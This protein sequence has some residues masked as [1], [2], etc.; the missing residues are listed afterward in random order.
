[1]QWLHRL[2]LFLRSLRARLTIW[3]SAVV[4]VAVM[5]A[6][7]AV[8]EGLRFS[9]LAETDVVLNDECK[10]LLLAMDQWLPNEQQLLGEME[11]KGESHRA[12]GWHIR[13]L[14][15]KRR[16]LWVG[17]PG[18]YPPAPLTD[19]VATREGANVYSSATHRCVERA[20][21][22]P[23]LPTYYVRVGTTTRFVEEDVDRL[24]RILAPIALAILLLAPMGGYILAERAVAPLHQVIAAADRLRPSRL[25][26]RLA[27][28]GVGDEL[29]QLASKINSFLDEIADHLR[30][31]RDF[32]AN[33]AHELR[34]PLTAIQSSVDVT[35][36]KS[37]TAVEYEELLYSIEDECRHLT[38]LVNQLL[39]LAEAESEIERVPPAPT[40][41][42][43]V[44]RHTVEMFAPVAEERGVLLTSEVAQ[45]ADVQG[46]RQHLRQLV[47]NLVDNAVKFTPPGQR[48]TVRVERDSAAKFVRLIVADTGIG[49]SRENLSRIFDRFYQVDRARARDLENRGNGLGLSIC[50]AI[51]QRLGGSIA[52]D[53]IPGKGTTFTVT[54]N[55]ALDGPGT[56]R[57]AA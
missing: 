42:D 33:A 27:I 23:G 21:S 53:S 34:S 44:V 6:L 39:Q 8:R 31:N 32:V 22:K 2:S 16:T 18:N 7:L 29:D 45:P 4:L 51:V 37:R 11:R 28:R 26:E 20:F 52:V 30:R 47:T 3:N 41:L 43:D 24:T 49:I 55:A 38:Q 46:N 40:P 25:D 57:T 56:N 36:E 15:E 9:L 35:L 10:E 54:L 14:D 13:W 48:V 50:Q 17:P 12:R 1:M 5:V 19:L